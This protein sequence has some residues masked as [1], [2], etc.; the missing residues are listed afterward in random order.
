MAR[1]E[2]EFF[3]SLTADDGSMGTGAVQGYNASQLNFRTAPV[4]PLRKPWRPFEAARGI[5]AGW[6][7]GGLGT[8]TR[9]WSQRTGFP[10][11]PARNLFV[12]SG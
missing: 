7:L 3:H 9:L 6:M 4:R 1:T 5:S 12:Q 10:A 11:V 2:L 8:L